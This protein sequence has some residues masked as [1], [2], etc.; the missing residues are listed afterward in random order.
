M[1]DTLDAKSLSSEELQ[2]LLVNNFENLSR[3]I[4]KLNESLKKNSEGL[5]VSSN[6]SKDLKDTVTST[7]KIFEQVSVGVTNILSKIQGLE[8]VSK[9]MSNLGGLGLGGGGGKRP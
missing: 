5:L 6:A 1:G 2:T 4:D 9:L 8:L 7:N 3:Q